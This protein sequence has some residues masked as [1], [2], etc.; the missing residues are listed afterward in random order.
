MTSSQN[1]KVAVIIGVGPENGMGASLCRRFAA[2]NYHVVVA[3]R[4][5]AKIET[6]A[7]TITASGGRATAVVCDATEVDTL[8]ALFSTASDLGTIKLA[9]YNAG[10]NMPGHFL[11]MEPG[12]FEKCWRIACF[13]GFLFSQLALKHMAPNEE[14]TLLFT[15]ASASMRGKPFFSAFTSAKAGLRA[16]AQSLAREFGPKGIH[17]AHVVIDGAIDGDRINKGRPEVAE[18]L[19]KEGL[20]DIEGIVDIYEM[21][22]Q[23]PS[24]AWTHEIDVRTATENF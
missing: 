21:L 4:T 13:G 1:E 10:N 15:G 2:A 8:E 5:A 6:V 11:E 18:A 16:L 14:G 12:Y 23:Q 22:E 3:G 20:V 19:G 7:E 24:R 17:V 9:I